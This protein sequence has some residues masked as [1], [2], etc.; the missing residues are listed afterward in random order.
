MTLFRSAFGQRLQVLG[1]PQARRAE[2]VDPQPPQLR[3]VR[4]AAQRLA[5]V[6]DQAAHV[7]ARAALDPQAQQRL[8]RIEQVGRRLQ[9]EG[10]RSEEH[11]SE[12]QSLMRISYADFCLKKKNKTTT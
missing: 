1:R 11:T 3:H 2:R 12:L 5:Q 8:A 10:V 4:A 7:G 9:L 6:A